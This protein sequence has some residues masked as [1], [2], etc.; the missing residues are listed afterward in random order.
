MKEIETENQFE[1]DNDIVNDLWHKLGDCMG[2]EECI[3]E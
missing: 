3:E 1:E 2:E